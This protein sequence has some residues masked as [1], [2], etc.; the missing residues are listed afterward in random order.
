M[1]VAG[2]GA[3]GIDDP[4]GAA[5]AG[6]HVSFVLGD[7]HPKAIRHNGCGKHGR[8]SPGPRRHRRHRGKH[9]AIEYRWGAA[10]IGARTGCRPWRPQGRRDR[11]PRR[12]D[13]Q[14]TEPAS[15][16]VEQ[17]TGFEPVVV[18]KTAET[19][20]PIPPSPR[21]CRPVIE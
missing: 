21:Q 20:G 18:L 1:Q 2:I 5:L 17:P 12:T 9:R 4:L 6:A 14:S 3:E 11:V 16:A 13:P 19:L 10:I 7:P 15:L 8:S